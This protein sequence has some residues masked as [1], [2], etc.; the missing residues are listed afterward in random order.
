MSKLTVCSRGH[1]FQ[2]DKDHPI[3]PTCWPGKYNQKADGAESI[4]KYIAG[5]PPQ[6]Q[7]ILQKIRKTIRNQAPNASET[8]SYAIP[9][10]DLNG[11]HLIHYA[12][13]K[14]HIGLFPTSS[15]VAAFKV[16]LTDYK[17]S[18]GTIQFPLD[19]PIPYGLIKKITVFR[20]E[21][22]SEL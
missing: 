22:V 3:C 21:E 2:K 18:K 17:T 16:Q 8:I 20:V 1:E 10:F 13:F 12:G 11:K 15:G 5:F 19:K 14:K 9:T 4:D 7:E 6:V